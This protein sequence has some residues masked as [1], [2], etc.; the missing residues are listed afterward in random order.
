MDAYKKLLAQQPLIVSIM[1]ANNEIGTIQDIKTLAAMAH[2]AGALFHTDA[3]QAAGKIPVDVKDW[4]VDYL[5]ISGHKIYAPKGVG[6]LF[7]KHG[8]PV[9]PFILGGHQEHG[10]RAGTYNAPVIAAFGYAAELAKQ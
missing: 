9:S 1:T 6:A 7:V 10:L 4:N 2:D 5:T 8:A 3:V